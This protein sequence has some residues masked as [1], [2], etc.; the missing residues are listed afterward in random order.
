[1]PRIHIISDLHMEFGGTVTCRADADL[2]IL[3]G[4]IAYGTDGIKW[5]MENFPPSLPVVYV[6]GNHEYYKGTLQDILRT[7]QL[8][9]A[10]SNIQVLDQETT[11]VCGIRIIGATLW[12]DY[13][14]NSDPEGAIGAARR[15]LNDHKLIHYRRTSGEQVRF[16]PVHAL[17]EHNAAR[18][19]LRSELLLGPPSPTPTVVVTHH[20]PSR[21]SIHDM[22]RSSGLNACFASNVD[23]LIQATRAKLWVHGHVHNSFDY[24]IG[25]TRV[26]CNP[27]GYSMDGRVENVSFNPSLVVSI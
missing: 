1:M 12:T 15:Q 7:M 25:E 4:D 22:Y 9:S 16:D 13:N 5:A 24:R 14:L 11:V 3:A 26:V 17:K 6:P 19:Y 23:A 27:R 21:Q 2:V 10:G 18:R 8:F 20:A